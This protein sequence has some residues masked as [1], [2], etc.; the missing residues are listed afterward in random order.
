M[1]EGSY[2]GWFRLTGFFPQRSGAY[3]AV[4]AGTVLPEETQLDW[5]LG[6]WAI[7]A[8]T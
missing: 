7:C 4:E 1:S 6:S 5:A 2:G 3:F 8:E